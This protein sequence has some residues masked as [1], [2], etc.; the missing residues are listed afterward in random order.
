MRSYG[1]EAPPIRSV[2]RTA[3]ALLLC[4][5]HL[6]AHGQTVGDKLISMRQG[7]LITVYLADRTKAVGKL[8][9]VRP[10]EFV[11]E[12]AKAGNPPRAIRYADVQRVDTRMS[13]PRKLAWFGLVYG[14][15]VAVTATVNN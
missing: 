7:Q 6:S 1:Q 11:L 4:L 5:T 3:L 8:G 14:I 12:P 13:G 9:D 2:S 10:A 15:L